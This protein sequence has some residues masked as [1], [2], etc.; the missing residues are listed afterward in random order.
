MST[1]CDNVVKVTRLRLQKFTVF[2][3]SYKWVIPNCKSEGSI[4]SS[5]FL[6]DGLDE[7][8][9]Y[10][11]LDR[12]NASFRIALGKEL[13][14]KQPILLNLEASV[15]NSN[16]FKKDTICSGVQTFRGGYPTSFLPFQRSQLIPESTLQENPE[17]IS[18]K[19][20]KILCNF[21]IID[22]SQKPFPANTTS[23][24]RQDMKYL[25]ENHT[26]TDVILQT[27]N[28]T[29]K[30]HKA[31]LSARS[32]VFAATFKGDWKENK[33]NKVEV[34][35]M[36]QDVLGELLTFMYTDETPNLTTMAMS[37]LAAA[38]RYNVESLK[39]RCEKH[40]FEYMT[41][42]NAAEILETANLHNAERLKKSAVEFIHFH[43]K[44]FV[45]TAGYKALRQS[46]GELILE[47]FEADTVL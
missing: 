22:D 17:V 26:N 47:M 25:L 10:F 33:E 5:N 18:D 7:V 36:H 35:D 24:L 42:E 29:F 9:F 46:N 4:T 40:L 3:C 12:L 1:N 37:L 41:V 38:D 32:P 20:L 15:L 11:I 8:Q 31:I 13:V 16:D 21:Q 23:N 2:Q 34:P 44:S 6:I 14:Y 45:K 43:R 30:A 27:G 28:K 19:T 39:S